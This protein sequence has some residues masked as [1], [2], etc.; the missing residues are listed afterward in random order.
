M[1]DLAR[2]TGAG[3]AALEALSSAGAVSW[4]S[5]RE[6]LW[7]SGAAAE[8]T[9][10]RLPGTVAGMSPPPLPEMTAFEELSADLK[11][12][13][14]SPAMSPM[15][16]A[17]DALAALGAVTIA[18]LVDVADRSRVTVAGVVTHRQR[19]ATAGGVTFLNLEDE[20]G[21]LN[22]ICS[23]G[24]WVRYRRAARSAVAMLVRGRLER[25]EG[26]D[27]LALSAVN[28][29]AE[30][31]EEIDLPAMIPATLGRSRDFR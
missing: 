10:E 20:T 16:F 6:A 18:S 7:A 8:S 26:G 2:R 28:L 1:E 31:L 13:G 3:R 23:R 4:L 14:L 11:T 25:A 9:P 12:L 5:R 27:R 19:P 21:L 29:I 22:V 30:H 17:R 24:T 15:G